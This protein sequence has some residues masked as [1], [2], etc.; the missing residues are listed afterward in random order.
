MVGW[1]D[2]WMVGW[3]SSIDVVKLSDAAA[4]QDPRPYPS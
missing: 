1:L 4:A 2:G 3:A